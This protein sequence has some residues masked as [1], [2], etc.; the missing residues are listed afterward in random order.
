MKKLLTA[1]LLIGLISL[2]FTAC[3]KSEDAENNSK[4][5]D[6]SSSSNVSA[7]DSKEITLEDVLNHE[8]SPES[9]FEYSADSENSSVVGLALY[10][11]KESIVVVPETLDGRP[12]VKV[13]QW[14]FSTNSINENLGNVRAIKFA[15]SIVE[16]EESACF[17]ENLEIVVL[18][19]GMKILNS[20]S[21][22]QCNSL[23]EVILNENLE[24]IKTCAFALCE[25]L[26]SIEIPASV[27]TIE[28][29]AFYGVN[30][31]FTIYGKADSTA[32]KFAKSEGIK[33]VAK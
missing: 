4:S 10:S 6:A 25:D 29:G 2:I 16:F 32:E 18:G 20:Y 33:F 30:K 27:K 23:R 31:D 21:F 1:I 17:H 26:K 7:D 8:T 11:G 14:A 5:A 9:D 13:D 19:K 28:P 3:G 22:L 15:D 12:V 24:T